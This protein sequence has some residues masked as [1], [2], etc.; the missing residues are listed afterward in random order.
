M[1]N[2]DSDGLL[3]DPNSSNDIY[4]VEDNKVRCLNCTSDENAYNDDED[5]ENS[6]IKITKDGVSITDD[7]VCSNSKS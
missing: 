5:N 7:T 2:Y 1:K 3:L 4:R 6:S